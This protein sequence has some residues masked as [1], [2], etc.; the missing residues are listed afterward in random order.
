MSNLL[1]Y[2]LRPKK[3]AALPA[4]VAALPLRAKAVAPTMTGFQAFANDNVSMA[5]EVKKVSRDASSAWAGKKVD[6]A[7]STGFAAFSRPGNSAYNALKRY[8]P[9]AGVALFTPKTSGVEAPKLELNK[10][11]I[12]VPT[13]VPSY[14]L[15]H[16]F[17]VP[18]FEAFKTT[19]PGSGEFV[20]DTL[21]K[22]KPAFKTPAAVE[23]AAVEVKK[24]DKVDK[25][26]AVE[27]SLSPEIDL[28]KVDSRADAAE[29]ASSTAPEDRPVKNLGSAAN[30]K[31]RIASTSTSNADVGFSRFGGK[32]RRFDEVD[33][34]DESVTLATSSAALKAPKRSKRI[35]A[36]KA[37]KAVDSPLAST[38]ARSLASSSSTSSLNKHAPVASTSKITIEDLKKDKEV[39][40][41]ER[42]RSKLK[43]ASDE[44][45]DVK[46]AKKRKA[47]L[48]G[49]KEKARE[50][51]VAG[52]SRSKTLKRTSEELEDQAPAKKRK[53]ASSPSPADDEA[54]A[55]SVTSPRKVKRSRNVGDLYRGG[56]AA[57]VVDP[58]GSSGWGRSSTVGG[59]HPAL[60]IWG[61]TALAVQGDDS[62]RFEELD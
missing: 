20:V 52:P 34:D 54:L 2:F 48:E 14:Q 8:H 33:A 4:V 6:A 39:A 60:A 46:P 36:A 17:G 32:R 59:V 38:S 57:A 44:L 51:V 23:D 18:A 29:P 45:E 24:V 13:F 31:G 41:S 3:A 40:I 50:V 10:T 22:A 9:S 21:D 27:R 5:D 42:R 62:H 28:E 61:E 30:A 49:L 53:T 43:R 25:G 35:E 15:G 26:K 7:T 58:I 55:T 11:K 16:K 1:A 12:E 37:A 47:S 56:F 19:K